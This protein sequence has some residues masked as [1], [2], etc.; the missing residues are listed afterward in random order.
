MPTCR[1]QLS[2]PGSTSS[3]VQQDLANVLHPIVQHSDAV[4]VV[5]SAHGDE[6]AGSGVG[7]ARAV[8][9]LWLLRACWRRSRTPEFNRDT[10]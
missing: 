1:F 3:R 9:K 7:R 2:R 4:T 8:L 10:R 5:F 6:P